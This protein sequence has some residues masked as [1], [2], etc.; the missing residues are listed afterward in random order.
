MIGACKRFMGVDEKVGSADEREDV[1]EAFIC[2]TLW[3]VTGPSEIEGERREEEE[4][5]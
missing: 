2:L 5:V 3:W 4:E 1:E